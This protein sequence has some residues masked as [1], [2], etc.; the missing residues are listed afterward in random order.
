MLP[1]LAVLVVIADLVCSFVLTALAFLVSVFAVLAVCLVRAALAI[2]MTHTYC[3]C[4]A[5]LAIV[6]AL[7]AFSA[8]ALP[9][10]FTVFL[11]SLIL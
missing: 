11:S 3:S 1:S 9:F 6:D 7:A 4:F 10:L 2:I 5:D 8:L